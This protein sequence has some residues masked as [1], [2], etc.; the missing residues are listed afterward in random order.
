MFPWPS[1]S[2]CLLQ[3]DVLRIYAIKDTFSNSEV[4]LFLS[5][6]LFIC[7]VHHRLMSLGLEDG[8]IQDG[9]ISTSSKYNYIAKLGRLQLEAKVGNAGA[10][11]VKTADAHQWLQIDF[12]GGTIVTKVVTQDEIII[13]G[14]LV[15]LSPT[16]LLTPTGC[17]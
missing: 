15:M 2:N 1:T 7:L 17:R 9:A 12:G 6:F 4:R 11:C 13:N 10:W 3:A 14:S 16:A 8:R 5:M